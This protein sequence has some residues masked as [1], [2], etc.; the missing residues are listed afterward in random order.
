MM[1]CADTNRCLGA[2]RPEPR[3]QPAARVAPPRLQVHTPLEIG[4]VGKNYVTPDE[5]R[6]L[7]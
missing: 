5:R 2:A 4:R 1:A 3:N 7:G 6:P